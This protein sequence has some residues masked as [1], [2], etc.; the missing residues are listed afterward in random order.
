MV[1]GEKVQEMKIIKVKDKEMELQNDK[2]SYYFENIPELQ[3]LISNI[4]VLFCKKLQNT[5]DKKQINP[6]G[7]IQNSKQISYLLF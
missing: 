6:N 5:N 4:C 2:M 3:A 7:N 1:F